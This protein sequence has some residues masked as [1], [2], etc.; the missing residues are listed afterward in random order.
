MAKLP[1]RVAGGTVT[2]TLDLK[3]IFGVS[4]KKSQSMK[5]KL[6]QALIDK[7]KDRIAEGVDRFGEEMAPYSEVYKESFDYIAARKDGTVNMRLTGDMLGNI[8][9]LESKGDKVTIGFRGS[10][11][12]LKAYDH[13]MGTGKLPVRQ[14]F[15]VS[16]SEVDAVKQEYEQELKILSEIKATELTDSNRVS[17]KTLDQLRSA[18][19]VG[20][21]SNIEI[22]ETKND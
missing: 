16:E 9:I 22:K 2:Q 4:F 8:D 17:Y 21:R 20:N 14:F 10:K 6:T 7:M 15:G 11:E 1:V 13:M 18:I 5:L 19:E 3:E 12:N